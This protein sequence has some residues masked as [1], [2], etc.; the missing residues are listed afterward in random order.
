LWNNLN[1]PPYTSF[2]NSSKLSKPEEGTLEWLVQEEIVDHEPEIQAENTSQQSLCARDFISWKSSRESERLLVTAPPGRGKSVLS[3]FVL[4]HLENENLVSSRKIV[5]YFCNIKND[6]ASRNANTILRALIVQLCEHEQRILQMIPSEYE[7]PVRFSSASFETLWNI[8]ERMLR[9]DT[10]AQIYCVIDGLDVYE[11]GMTELI[12]KLVQVHRNTATERPVLKLFCTTRPQTAISDFWGSSE[13]RILRCN[14]GDLDVFIE[15][16]VKSLGKSFRYNMRHVIKEQLRK[17]ADGTFL[18]LEVV[19]R[20]IAITK[21]PTLHRIEMIIKN[22]PQ[23]LDSL[24]KLLLQ[25]LV[26]E[27]IYIA[28]L[29]VWVVYARCPLDLEVLQVAIAHDP[30]KTYTNSQQ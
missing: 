21:L 12:S 9:G 5:Y 26:Q 1:Q 19:F 25:Q 27:D 13:R 30:A 6:V 7:E 22:S 15:S 24:Y 20:R 8:F 3:N 10:Y 17:Q 18:W 28:R 4:R 14:P 11:E 23:D 2:R 29:L 16:R